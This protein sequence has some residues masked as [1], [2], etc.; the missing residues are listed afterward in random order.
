MFY[1][2]LLPESYIFNFFKFL[3]YIYKNL[4][5]SRGLCLLSS[6]TE[7]TL[8][9]CFSSSIV[10][11]CI[12]KC[13]FVFFFTCATLCIFFLLPSIC[14]HPI[15]T[16]KSYCFQTRIRNC[17]EGSDAL[18]SLVIRQF[19][20]EAKL[21]T[22]SINVIFTNIHKYSQIVK[23]CCSLCCLRGSMMSL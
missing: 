5:H 22:I 14:F 8:F 4:L 10:V 11:F 21:L 1:I 23:T 19:F 12:F 9:H 13:K 3:K 17:F 6:V 20:A 16:Q 15:W 2:V 18:L 7:V